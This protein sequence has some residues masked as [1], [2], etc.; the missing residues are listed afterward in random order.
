MSE[1]KTDEEG[2]I[3]LQ[4]KAPLTMTAEI[5]EIQEQKEGEEEDDKTED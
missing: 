2:H 5:A 3:I 4:E 1:H